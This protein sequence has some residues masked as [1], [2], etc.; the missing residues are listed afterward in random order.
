LGQSARFTPD[1]KHVVVTT[2][3]EENFFAKGFLHF[4]DTQ[5]DKLVRTITNPS[6]VISFAFAEGGKK[7]VVAGWEDDF[8][9]YGG[10][11]WEQLDSFPNDP[12]GTSA[13]NVSAMPDGKWFLTGNHG[14]QG[15]RLWDLGTK[16]RVQFRSLS[17]QIGGADLS[18]DGNQCV[19]AYMA[20]RIDL[21]NTTTTQLTDRLQV[22]RGVFTSAKYSP[23]G[24]VIAT[25]HTD[26]EQFR[27]YLWDVDTRKLLHTCEGLQKYVRHLAFTPDS[28]YL[29]TF[30][31]S[32][33]REDPG[34]LSVWSVATG[35]RVKRFDFESGG[36][37]ATSPDGTILV[38]VTD[39]G[40][41]QKWDFAAIR[42]EFEARK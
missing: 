13:K 1:G 38:T 37:L 2:I 14:F 5:T 16:K 24:K 8:R 35:R 11:G 9:V 41:V 7:L 12:A 31:R 6:R 32:P 30:T 18:P 33:A 15:P 25:G 36:E 27:F 21:F 29:V 19:I 28:K 22:E 17:E 3:P 23:D 42:K 10:V 4:F 26:K 34:E 40:S 20:P 39:D